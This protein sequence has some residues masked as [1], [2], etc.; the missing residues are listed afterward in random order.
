M[1]QKCYLLFFFLFWYFC[2]FAIIRNRIKWTVALFLGLHCDSNKIGASS[3]SFCL[4]GLKTVYYYNI[5]PRHI[6]TFKVDSKLSSRLYSLR[7]C[8]DKN[9]VSKKSCHSIKVVL[10]FPN[11]ILGTILVHITFNTSNAFKCSVQWY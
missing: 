8:I 6:H 2:L 11:I 7:K 1:N 5:N 3:L 4:S 9:K 10:S